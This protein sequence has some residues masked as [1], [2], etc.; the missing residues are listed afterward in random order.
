MKELKLYFYLFF[1]FLSIYFSHEVKVVDGIDKKGERG[2]SSGL[3]YSEPEQISGPE[4]L[5]SLNGHCFLA[6]VDRYEYSVCPFQ[7]ITQRRVIGPSATL[8][9]VW[10]QWSLNETYQ[11]YDTMIYSNGQTCGRKGR[12]AKLVLSCGHPTFEI[13]SKSVKESSTCEHEMIL[14]I[15][16]ACNLLTKKIYHPSNSNFNQQSTVSNPISPDFKK[17]H[18]TGPN[19]YIPPVDQ[20]QPQYSNPN[21]NQHSTFTSS[22]LSTSSSSQDA[23]SISNSPTSTTSSTNPSIGTASN[24]IISDPLLLNLKQ[25]VI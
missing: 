24:S 6:S 1:S 15:P 7:N 11:V 14:G 3:S 2:S 25:Q 8:L 10:G 12:S 17:S 5:F 13:F 19:Q 22:S 18:S 23:T 20:K 21:P 16:L 9:G 4:A